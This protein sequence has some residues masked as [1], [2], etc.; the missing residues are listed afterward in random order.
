[1]Q[2]VFVTECLL[3]PLNLKTVALSPATLNV[4]FEQLFKRATFEDNCNV[5]LF[6]LSLATHLF[7][8]ISKFYSPIDSIAEFHYRKTK[9]PS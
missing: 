6:V 8:Y 1:M 2:C 7:E 5:F 3:E 9:Y 4:L